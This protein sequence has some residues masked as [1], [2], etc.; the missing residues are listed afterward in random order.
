M[1]RMT[2]AEEPKVLCPVCKAEEDNI[3][4][5]AKDHRVIPVAMQSGDAATVMKHL[6]ERGIDFRVLDQAA[7]FAEV[8]RLAEVLMEKVGRVV[9]VLPVALVATALLD[10]GAPL[11]MLELKARVLALVQRLAATAAH[12][13]IPRGDQDYAIE[14]GLRMLRM[15]HL[16]TERDGLY[17]AEPDETPLLRYYAN[18]IVHL[19]AVPA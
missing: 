11:S 9:P 12:V 7:R 3:V 15:R 13:H 19:L 5:V 6:K 14:V 18:S 2:M 1:R 17:G 16:V 10:A 8:E 4:S